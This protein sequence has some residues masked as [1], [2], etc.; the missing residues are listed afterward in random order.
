MKQ[1]KGITTM[2]DTNATHSSDLK[3]ESGHGAGDEFGGEDPP[4]DFGGRDQTR[5][6][7]PP[8]DEHEP[9]EDEHQP[10]EDD[11][12]PEGTVLEPGYHVF[13]VATAMPCRQDTLL[14][15]LT[16]LG[17]AGIRVDQ[18]RPRS[19][20]QLPVREH[21]FLANVTKRLEL[22]QRGVVRWL[23]AQALDTE[24]AREVK[25]FRLKL[26]AYN[27][28]RGMLYET[29]FLSRERSQPTRQIVEEH[30]NEMGFI[31]ES[32]TCIERD[33]RLADRPGVSVALWFG[34]L[35]WDAPASVVTEDD[36]FYFE[37]L[38]ARS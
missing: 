9:S 38:I 13:E 22:H 25:N 26:E 35:E 21:R 19:A 7:E 11:E 15:G 5:T 24:V 32:L 23:F 31:I 37:S 6:S 2:S 17:L 1:R 30:L 36:P 12:V 3:P 20:A 14:A 16:R 27:L 18:S 8:E 4:H 10:S 33:L 28:E 34:L 29:L